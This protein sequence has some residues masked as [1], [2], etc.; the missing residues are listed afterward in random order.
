MN[1]KR[2][3]LVV[4]DTE[5]TPPKDQDFSEELKT[6]DWKTER[7]VIRALKSLGHEVFTVGVFDDPALILQKVEEVRPDICFNLTEHFHGDLTLDRSVAGLYELLDIPYTGAGPTGLILCKNKGVSKKIMTYHRIKTPSFQVFH[8]GQKIHR[9][10]KLSFPILIKPLREEASYGISQNSL[11]YNEKEFAE[12]IEFVH[13]SMKK[14]A[15]A[16][17][18]IE[19]RELYVGILGNLR[20]QVFPVREMVFKEVPKED[21]KIATYKAKWDEEYRKKWGI[22]NQFANNLSAELQEKITE[23]C[24]KVYR[25]LYMRGYGRI[26]VRLTP[27]NEVAIIEA[28]PN[29]FLASDEDFA[30]SARKD[31]LEYPVLIQRILNLGF[32]P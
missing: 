26:D 23:T 2:K 7:H 16:E 5:G 18:Y 30:L 29:P 8:L 25:L 3:V 6:E 17:E 10:K 12:R 14:D 21:P 9:F 32:N 24:K 4:F 20:L 13:G 28:N 27:Q 15:I 22:E 1:Q 31:G 19:G 11:V